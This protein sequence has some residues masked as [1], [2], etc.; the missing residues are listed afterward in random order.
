[1]VATVR[2]EVEAAGLGVTLMHEHLF[3]LDAEVR[4]NYPETWDDEAEITH[5]VERLAQAYERGVR[6]MVDVTVLG[7]G[8]YV[9]RVIEVASRTPVNIVVATGLYTYDLVPLGFR[10]ER[11]RN[12]DIDLMAQIFVDDIQKGISTTGVRAGALKC[13]SDRHGI[14]PGVERSIRAVARAQRA[15]GVPVMTH[16]NVRLDPGGGLRQIDVFNDEG[17]PLDRVVIGHSDDSPDYDYL[18]AIAEAGAF[19][20]FDHLNP[21]VVSPTID[22]RVD[23]MIRLIEAGHHDRMILSHDAWCFAESYGHTTDYN[24]IHDTVVPLLRA[25]GLTDADLDR[26]LVRNPRHLFGGSSAPSAV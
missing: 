15:T 5:A 20:G 26:L 13:S 23:M 25:R 19:I 6:T 1:M 17:V 7:L 16:T 11:D 8:R 9:P 2:G 4:A 3:V 22:E 18:R 10:S 14:T 21:I 24:L 12:G